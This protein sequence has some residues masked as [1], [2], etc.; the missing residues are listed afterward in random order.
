MTKLNIYEMVTDKIIEQLEKGKIPWQK[1]WDS[2]YGM[3]CNMISKKPYRGMNTLLLRCTEYTSPFFMTFKQVNSLGGSIRKGEKANLVIFY[4]WIEIKDKYNESITDENEEIKKIPLLRYYNLFNIEQCDGI[5][6][7]KIP[8]PKKYNF[9][10]IQKAE[11]IINEIQSSPKINFDGSDACYIPSDDT[12]HMPPKTSFKCDEKMYS[13]LFHELCHWTG[14][15]SRLKRKGVCDSASFVSKVYSQEELVAEIGAA[16][17]CSISGIENK[18]IDNSTAYIA[19]WLNKLKDN[20]KIIIQAA[21]QA[22]KA[23]DFILNK[24]SFE[25][26]RETEQKKA[27]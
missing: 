24:N 8:K 10:P 12:I 17:L 6:E 9:N 7:S 5:P 18:T 25:E 15:E 1:P 11:L 23:C 4:R 16:F 26:K 20:K 2:I 22:Q 27:V 14:H 13:T 21:G 3:P 19:G